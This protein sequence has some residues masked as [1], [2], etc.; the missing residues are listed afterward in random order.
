MNT[1]II[2]AC[3]GIAWIAAA[4]S[5]AAPADAFVLTTQSGTY[6]ACS[7]QSTPLVKAHC[8][9]GS[10]EDREAM[11]YTNYTQIM[12]FNVTACSSGGC[13]LD[14]LT[15]YADFAYTA[16][17]KNVTLYQNPTLTSCNGYSYYEVGSCAC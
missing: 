13:S 4:V 2:K 14:T 8:R 9:V 15:V 7:G 1:S 12:K 11:Y 3:A 10:G 16:G 6:A 5:T 17:R